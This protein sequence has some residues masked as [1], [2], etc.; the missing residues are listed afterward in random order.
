MGLQTR[1]NRVAYSREE[2][3]KRNRVKQRGAGDTE[4]QGTHGT[5]CRDGVA[6]Q[7]R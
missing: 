6:E 5:G 2:T 3:T 4:K 7:N 1:R